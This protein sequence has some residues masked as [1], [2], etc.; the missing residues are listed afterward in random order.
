[1]EEPESETEVKDAGSVTDVLLQEE[2]NSNLDLDEKNL[3]MVAPVS[4]K[5]K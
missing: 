4:N 1:M 5:S 3:P 2:S